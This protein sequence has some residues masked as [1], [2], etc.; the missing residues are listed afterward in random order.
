MEV[1]VGA[2]QLAAG[3]CCLRRAHMHTGALVRTHT[4]TGRW[5]AGFGVWGF[6]IGSGP[7]QFMHSWWATLLAHAGCEGSG[8]RWSGAARRAHP[9]P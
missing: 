9:A 2:Y 7:I 1:G 4:H 8:L 3:A 6:V 5:C